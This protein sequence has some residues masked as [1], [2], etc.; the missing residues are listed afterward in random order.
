MQQK[1]HVSVDF[2]GTITLQD[3]TKRL[4]DRYADPTWMDVERLWEAGSI[5]ARECLS[6]QIALLRVSPREY[7]EFAASIEIDPAFYDFIKFCERA[8]IA[9]TVVSDG[10]DRTI[11]VVLKR[12]GLKLKVHA[13]RL[14]WRKDHWH[15]GF[16]GAREGCGTYSANCKCQFAETKD[17][18]QVLIGDGRSDFC[19]AGK[20]DLVLAKGSLADYCRE[21]LIN[22][23]PI[24]NFGNANQLFAKTFEMIKV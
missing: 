23:F 12:A 9:V 19:I 11:D 21:R 7:D 5:N 4:F 10:L 15:V 18:M 3:S 24:S 2:D 6:R 8:N 17:V 13:N 16:P 22:H 1:I 14:E 20:C